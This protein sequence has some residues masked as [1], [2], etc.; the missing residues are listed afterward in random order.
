MSCFPKPQSQKGKRKPFK[1]ALMPTHQE[2]VKSNH[3][4]SSKKII[5]LSRGQQDHLNLLSDFS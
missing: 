4:K 2:E 1:Q 5:N 3:E